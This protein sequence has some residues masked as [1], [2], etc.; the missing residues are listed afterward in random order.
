MRTMLLGVA[1]MVALAFTASVATSSPVG[2]VAVSTAGASERQGAAVVEAVASQEVPEA[3]PHVASM[4]PTWVRTCGFANCSV[5]F[6][7]SETRI[8]AYGGALLS[9]LICTMLRS[10]PASVF[11]T[12]I[13]W[14]V[15]KAGDNA[16]SGGRCV[17]I[18]FSRW[19]GVV[20][21][22]GT[23]TGWQCK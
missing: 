3:A 23:Y 14:A 13:S 8:A 18:S 11:C 15:G 10:T 19:T 17:K 4:H 5:Y 2:A 21:Y 22:I 9:T 20:Y 1:M 7:K 16:V 6:N 12:V